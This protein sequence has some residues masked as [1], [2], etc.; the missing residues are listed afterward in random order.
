MDVALIFKFLKALSKNNNREWFEKHK[1]TYLEAKESF[2]SFIGPFLNELVKFDQGLRGLEPKKLM[3]RIYRDVRFS[4]DKT[5]YKTNM[6]ASFSPAGKL[7]DVPGYYLHIEPGNKSMIAGGLYMPDATKL[8]KIRQEIDYNGDALKKIV[9][10]KQFKNT[11]G[12]FDDSE[13]LKTTPK[14]FPKDHVYSEWLKLKSYVVV[15][16]FTDKQVLDKAFMRNAVLTCKTLK[17][18]ND[19][20]K[21]ALE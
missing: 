1:P 19:F 16:Q 21:E 17:P 8:A 9:G 20:L 15:R 12:Q 11:F 5:P 18:L 7:V 14:N 10:S 6:S 13:K 3:F 4:K 2:E